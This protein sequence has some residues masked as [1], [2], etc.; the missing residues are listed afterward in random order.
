MIRVKSNGVQRV[1]T[2]SEFVDMAKRNLIDGID[3]DVLFGPEATVRD[4][5]NTLTLI[6]SEVRRATPPGNGEN[7]R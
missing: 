7:P 1:L 5:N 4:K 3:A 6:G 2:A